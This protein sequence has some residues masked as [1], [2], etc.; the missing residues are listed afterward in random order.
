MNMHSRFSRGLV[1]AAAACTLSL[2][3]FAG[4][5]TIQ[6]VTINDASSWAAGDLGYARGTSD[7]VQYIGCYINGSGSGAANGVCQARNAAGV[8][9]SCSTNQ[10]KWLD[11]IASVSGDS[12]VYFRWNT[13]GKCTMIIVENHSTLAPKKP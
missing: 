6:Q 10:P 12:N 9:R 7:D 3:A 13:D 5:K 11:I 1:I 8:T 4:M 2:G